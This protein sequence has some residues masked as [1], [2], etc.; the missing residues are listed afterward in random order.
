V[1]VFFE[2]A[3]KK[4]GKMVEILAAIAPENISVGDF[5]QSRPS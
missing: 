3:A 2:I 1:A 4:W 5:L